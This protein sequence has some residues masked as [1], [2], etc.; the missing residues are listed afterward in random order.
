[1]VE[2]RAYIERQIAY[3]KQRHKESKNLKNKMFYNKHLYYWEAK[4]AGQPYISRDAR[5][6]SSR[7]TGILG[8]NFGKSV[9]FG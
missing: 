3:F 1:M 9:R 2:N 7:R 5:R 8:L 6:K 4:L